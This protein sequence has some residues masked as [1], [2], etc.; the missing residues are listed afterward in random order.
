MFKKIKAYL[1]RIFVDPAEAIRD[2]KRIV[3]ILRI[4][5]QAINSTP[6]DDIL[7]AIPG[8]VDDQIVNAIRI[9][10][11]RLLAVVDA[12]EKLPTGWP[13]DTAAQNAILAKSGSI[14]LQQVHNIPELKADGLI[15]DFYSH[16]KLQG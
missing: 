16:T 6:A 9:A 11:N 10:L 13:K 2:A 3:R 5:R 12:A 14:A 1:K 7:K 4:V 8:N 15:Q